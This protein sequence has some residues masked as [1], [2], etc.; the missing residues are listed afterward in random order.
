MIDINKME[1]VNFCE[2]KRAGIG[3]NLKGRETIYL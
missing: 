3:T 1:T 2:Q